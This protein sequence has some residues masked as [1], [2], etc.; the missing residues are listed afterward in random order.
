MYVNETYSRV[1]VDKHLS[2]TFPIKNGLTQG[3]AVMQLLLNF[4]LKYTFRRDQVNQDGLQLNATLQLLAYADG[5]NIL[6]GAIHIIRETQNFISYSKETGIEVNSGKTKYMFMFLDRTV[7]Q[8]T[9]QRLPIFPLKG[10]NS[11]NIWKQP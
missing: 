8:V 7:D 4:A 10:W 5:V 1:W 11:S 9:V 2:D 3:D 6:G